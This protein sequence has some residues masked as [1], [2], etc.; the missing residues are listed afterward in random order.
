MAREYHPHPCRLLTAGA[1]AIGLFASPAAAQ[2]PRLEAVYMVLGSD[3]AIARAILKDARRCPLVSL[4]KIRRRMNVR[5]QPDSGKDAP[6]PV[7]VCELA[8]PA[9]TRSAR[10]QGRA[11]PLVP[12]AL[13]TIAVLGDTGCRVKGKD[14]QDCNTPAQWPFAQVSRSVAEARP[15]LVVHVGDY[16]YRESPCPPGNTGCAGSPVGDSWASWKA[17]FFAPAAPLLRAAPWIMARGN[18]EDC[19]RAGTGYFR[20]LDPT[21]AQKQTPPACVD[22]SPTYTVTAGGKPFIVMDT[23]GADDSC[24]ATQCNSALYAAAFKSLQPAAGSWWISHRP[25]WG[26]GKGFT[27]NQALQ[28]ALSAWNGKLPDGIDLALSGHMHAFELLSFADGRT[29]QFIIGNG[30][31]KLDDAIDKPLTGQSIGG[32]TVSDGRVQ[33]D[34]GFTLFTPAQDGSWTA[35][36]RDAA[37]RP[38][39]ACTVKPNEAKCE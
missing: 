33:Y 5:A 14:I 34:F 28:Q 11:L 4:D 6:F 20:F 12:S 8:I 38:Q 22:M 3:G 30:G 32:T 21:L 23:S 13:R 27:L 16:H 15:S 39:F 18:H 36:V 2:Q 7:L 17:D 31:S 37:G 25:A 9:D 1:L 19:D 29:P 24:S 35:S 26:V 10:I